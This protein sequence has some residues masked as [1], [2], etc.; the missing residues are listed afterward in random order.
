MGTNAKVLMQFR[1]R[2]ARFQRWD[3]DA[4]HGPAVR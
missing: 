4:D 2:P 1:H 3:G